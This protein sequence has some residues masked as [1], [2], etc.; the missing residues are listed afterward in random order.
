MAYQKIRKISNR[1][2]SAFWKY[3][4]IFNLLVFITKYGVFNN[5]VNDDFK[6]SFS[7]LRSYTLL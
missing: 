4:T 3:L 2:L 1:G 5:A 7:K 6:S